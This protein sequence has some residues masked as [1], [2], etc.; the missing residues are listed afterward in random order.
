VAADPKSGTWVVDLDG[1]IWLAADP[2]AG[3]AAAVERL[4]AAGI[5]VLFATNNAATTSGALI[6]RLASAGIV[7]DKPDL[8][9]S[10]QAAATLLE[11]G[12]RA[13][14]CGGDGLREALGDRGVEIVTEGP[15][16]A[17]V[18][19]WTRSFDFDL[20]AAS[21]TIVRSGARLIGTNDDPTYPTPAGLI[22]GAGSILAAVARASQ[23]EPEVAG[24]P[25]AAM[26][27][28]VRDRAP[29]TTVVVGDRP[30]TDGLFA[31]R[32]G[33]RFALVHSG[34]TPASHGKL[35]P[36]PDLEA[37]NFAG[38]VDLVLGPSLP[39]GS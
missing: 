18:V 30:A 2:I 35:E 36:E 22:P 39:L 33:V 6:G 12:A 16:Q 14:V 7:V 32:M 13:F 4:R 20:L 27:S 34:V 31:S 3:S 11:P 21:M 26:A 25:Y 9:S 37:D 38:V 24:K 19:G 15:A 10:A 1:V 23:N 28:L 29:D 8:V 5:R 17:V